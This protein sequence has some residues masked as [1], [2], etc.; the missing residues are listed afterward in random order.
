MACSHRLRLPLSSLNSLTMPKYATFCKRH[1]DTLHDHGYSTIFVPG[2]QRISVVNFY[3]ILKDSEPNR[4]LLDHYSG[5]EILEPDGNTERFDCL[6]DIMNFVIHK[7]KLDGIIKGQDE[8][9]E[10]TREDAE[11]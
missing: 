11:F 8:D 1:L 4:F 2:R 5:W 6:L 7:Y 10:N 9:T 3:D